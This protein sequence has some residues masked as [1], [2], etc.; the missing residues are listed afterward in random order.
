MNKVLASGE[1]C[2][3]GTHNN[4]SLNIIHTYMYNHRLTT[5]THILKNLHTYTPK[6]LTRFTYIWLFKPTHIIIYIYVC[7][8]FKFVV[9]LKTSSSILGS[10]SRTITP[11]LF[12]IWSKLTKPFTQ[13]EIKS[14]YMYSSNSKS[15]PRSCFEY[16]IVRFAIKYLDSLNE[17]FLRI[18]RSCTLCQCMRVLRKWNIFAFRFVFDIAN[19]CPGWGRP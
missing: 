17:P 5:N 19:K 8:F 12:G 9:S 3:Y 15:K 13:T 14:Y 7:T 10:S 16:N 2:L 18:M 1:D 11:S 4:I 6:K